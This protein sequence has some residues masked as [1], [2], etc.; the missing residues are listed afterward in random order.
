[1]HGHTN[2]HHTPRKPHSEVTR[3]EEL[4]ELLERGFGAHTSDSTKEWESQQERIEALHRSLS[5]LTFTQKRIVVLKYYLG[6]THSDIAL[7]LGIAPGT[8]EQHVSQ[9]LERLRELMWKECANDRI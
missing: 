4:G 9:L 6:R 5:Q 7:S 1:M 3:S 8:V 2:N